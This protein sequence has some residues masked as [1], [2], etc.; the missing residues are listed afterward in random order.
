[1]YSYM[2]TRVFFVFQLTRLSNIYPPSL[3]MG[4]M[5]GGAAEATGLGCVCFVVINPRVL[6]NRVDF[7]YDCGFIILSNVEI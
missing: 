7:G 4:V 3:G 5:W 2:H 6:A 1:M